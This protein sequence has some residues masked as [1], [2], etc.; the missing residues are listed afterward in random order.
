M[1]IQI[2]SIKNGRVLFERTA[3][4]NTF[5]D[6]VKAALECGVSLRHADFRN[7]FF[8]NA[9]F[10]NA[11][12]K[13]ADFSNADLHNIDFSN[14]KLQGANMKGATL[15]SVKMNNATFGGGAEGQAPTFDFTPDPYLPRK[16]AQAVLL[17]PESLQMHHW[18]LC[19]TTHCLA[20]WAIHLSGAAG[21]ALESATSPSV[22][23]MMLMP[24]AAHLF[25]TDIDS[26]RKWLER[27][28]S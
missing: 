21:Y 8:R 20:G 10:S 12:F 24:S 18:H 22:A 4:D 5:I 9:D 13:H 14:A 1:K 7:A 11:D 27:Q 23:G 26:A 6:T 3:E 16:V 17:N 28:L 15:R 19:E 2:I 25:Y